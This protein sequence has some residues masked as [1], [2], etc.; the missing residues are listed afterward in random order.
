MNDT[1][2]II[3]RLVHLINEY[4]GT[5]KAAYTFDAGPNA[6]IYTLDKDVDLLVSVMS[7]YFPPYN[8]SNLG[9]YCNDATRLFH[10]IQNQENL[11]SSLVSLLDKCGRVPVA[12]DVKY[13]FITKS[14]PGPINVGIEHSLLDPSTGLPVPPRPEHRQLKIST[15]IPSAT[16]TAAAVEGQPFIPDSSVVA[17]SHS[18]CMYRR[19]GSM[20]ITGFLIVGAFLLGRRY[21]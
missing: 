15:S 12:G 14:G 16:T 19:F 4:Y 17:V 7:K 1:S 11:P 21:K 10:A 5:I 13:M 6:V 8:H 2:R 3:I 18:H 20:F 9:E